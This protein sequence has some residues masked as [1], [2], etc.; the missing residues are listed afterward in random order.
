[1]T[2]ALTDRLATLDKAQLLTLRQNAHR[3]ET[4]AGTRGTE[5]MALLPLI[6]AELSKR[7]PSKTAASSKAASSKAAKKPSSKTDPL[8]EAPA[9]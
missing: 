5:A 7:S 1:M 6:D 3:L 9:S 4:E 8:A 2:L